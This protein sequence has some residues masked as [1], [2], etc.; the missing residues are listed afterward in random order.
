MG[1]V[2]ERVRAQSFSASTVAIG[3]LVVMVIGI[4]VGANT[5]IWN[6]GLRT[7]GLKPNVPAL[8]LSSLQQTYE[9]LA[10]NYDGKVD[11]AKLIDGANHGLV[12]A[13]GDPHTVYFSASEASAFN[14]G[15]NGAYSGIGA[16]LDL[17]DSVVTIASVLDGSPA[18]KAGLKSGDAIVGVDGQSAEGWTI[19]KAATTIQG[20][21]GTTVKLSFVRDMTAMDVSI[22]RANLTNPSVTSEIDDGIGV[23]RLSRFSEDTTKLANAA[24]NSFRQANVKGVILDLRGNGG[25]EVTAAQNVASLWLDNKVVMTARVN[26]ATVQTLKSGTHPTLAGI[27]TIVLI[28]GGS[29][30][31]SEIVASALHDNGVATL[32][33]QKSY[34]KGSEQSV[35]NLMDGSQLKVTSAHWYTPDGKNIDKTGI[36]PDTVITPTDTQIQAGDDPAKDSALT[37]LGG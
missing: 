31:A 4:G 2:I 15:L 10:A 5:G 6:S 12:S 29:A 30:S 20:K 19:E 3:G 16:V 17:K 13:L 26:G 32:F 14:D 7:L 28:D 18:Q 1:V 22:V 9:Q 25:G 27:P 37:K 36:M 8:D 34:G 23:L 24:A 21:A 33:G 35:L 11:K